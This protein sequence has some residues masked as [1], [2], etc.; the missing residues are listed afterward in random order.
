V[1]RLNS[2]GQIYTVDAP[3]GLLDF[4]LKTLKGKSRNNV[5]SLLTRGAVS[6]GGK[7]VTRHDYMLTPGQTVTLAAP[8]DDLR[9][10][11]T[12]RLKIIYE[13]DALIAA[14]KPAGLLSIATERESFETAYHLLTDYVRI[15]SPKSRIFVVHRLDRDTSGVMIAA[16]NEAMKLA[17][18]DN[19]GALVKTRGYTA[20]AEGV[21]RVKSGV[22]RSWLKETKTHVVYS[23]G[24]DGDGQEAVTL[25]DVTRESGAYSL[26]Q[27][28]L[29]TGRKNQIRV[30]L[31][32]LGHPVAG[33]KKYGAKTDPLKRLCLHAG[34][35]ELEHP[36]SG[37]LM[38]FESAVPKSFLSLF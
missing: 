7:T 33:D 37:Q 2:Q 29:E 27:L 31:S 21:F 22:I 30:H 24:R 36:F 20:V 19:W 3:A 38:T 34:L 1:V 26:V 16:K 32:D 35:L 5:K 13:D 11:I 14:D 28:A 18:Q 9:K 15:G 17:L 10:E 25:F 4:L 8:G 6:V 23:G 12:K